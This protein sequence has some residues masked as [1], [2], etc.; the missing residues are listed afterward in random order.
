MLTVY[1]ENKHD[2][3]TQTQRTRRHGQ[4]KC[5]QVLCM[6]AQRARAG[7]G[8]A[9]ASNEE[10]RALL[11]LV[12]VD[13]DCVAGCVCG[14]MQNAQSKARAGGLYVDHPGYF[15]VAQVDSRC[16]SARFLLLTC[17][18]TVVVSHRYAR[19][20]LVEPWALPCRASEGLW[21]S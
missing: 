1:K 8:M 19:T 16:A 21:I 15:L 12:V 18:T 17:L 5:R 14:N 7:R 20:L 11:T 2:K 3:H 9:C 10:Q 13:V 4:G 6:R